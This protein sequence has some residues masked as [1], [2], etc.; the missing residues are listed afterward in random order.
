MSKDKLEEVVAELRRELAARDA[1]I[2]ELEPAADCWDAL[3]ACDRI[4]CMGWAEL[5]RPDAAGMWP[6]PKDAGYAHAT[7]NFWTGSQQ[8]A[9]AKDEQ[10]KL[11]REVL[12]HFIS[13]ALLNA[14]V[15][16]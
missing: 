10:D 13:K 9:A 3:C 14:K 1:R 5:G 15:R 7:F 6:L 16:P 12:S 2:A 8:R 4:T 11:G